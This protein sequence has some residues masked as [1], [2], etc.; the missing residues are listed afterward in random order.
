MPKIYYSNLRYLGKE[1]NPFNGK[2]F[3]MFQN[4]NYPMRISTSR[5]LEDLASLQN[6]IDYSIK[7]GLKEDLNESLIEHT[8]MLEIRETIMSSEN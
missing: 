2:T 4:K 7:K 6:D 5:F 1:T 3:L 8:A